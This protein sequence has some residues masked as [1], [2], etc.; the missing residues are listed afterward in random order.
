M[1]RHINS[2]KLVTNADNDNLLRHI[3]AEFVTS[4]FAMGQDNPEPSG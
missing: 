2:K 1:V 4:E 3:G